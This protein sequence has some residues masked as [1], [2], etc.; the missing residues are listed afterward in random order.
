MAVLLWA[1]W[2]NQF[3]EGIVRKTA[4][5][6]MQ[7]LF[8]PFRSDSIPVNDL[9]KKVWKGFG[10]HHFV[11]LH[12]IPNP[13]LWMNR[14]LIQIPGFALHDQIIATPRN[15]NRGIHSWGRKREIIWDA[16]KNY[17]FEVG[18]YNISGSLALVNSKE[19]IAFQS[20]NFSPLVF[21]QYPRTFGIDDSLSIQEG[22][23]GSGFLMRQALP[24]CLYRAARLSRLPTDKS[25]GNKSSND[26]KP[27][28]EREPSLYLHILFALLFTAIAIWGGQRIVDRNR[29]RRLGLAATLVGFFELF[30][31]LSG[32]GLGGP[33]A[34]WRFRW[35][36]GNDEYCNY[37][38]LHNGQIVP[39]KYLRTIRP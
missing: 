27:C 23:F 15:E 14:N 38:P 13:R 30:C 16:I 19:Q 20:F 7:T 5:G 33:F 8:V 35:L 10:L 32:F 36:L 11:Q 22:C 39:Q 2:S 21:N 26:Q 29:Y 18:L 4:S 17:R 31:T 6:K 3:H 28:V 34:F 25:G 12:L 9:S 24:N 37:Q 1:S